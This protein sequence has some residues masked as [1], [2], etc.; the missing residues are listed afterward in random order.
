MGRLFQYN[1]EIVARHLDFIDDK[2]LKVVIEDRLGELE[3]VFSVN[4][5]L[6][7][8]ILSISC[9]EG[10]FK[11]L[12]SI[13]ASLIMG[14]RK[15]PMK[16]GGKKKKF[17][18]LTIEEIYNLLLEND[19]LQEIENFDQIYALFRSYRN[20]IH[21]QKQKKESWPVGLGQAQMA[22]GLLNATID[23]I[24]KYI[25]IGSEIFE[26]ISGSPRF[27]LSRILHL[28]VANIRTNSFIVLRRKID[29][30]FNVEFDLELGQ[31]GILNFVFDFV[32]EG[33]FK[34]LRLDNRGFRTPNCVLHCTQRYVWRQI[35]FA[36]P[37]LPPA[38]PTIP[39]KISADFAKR[40]FSLCV[41]GVGYKFKDI[42]G[43]DVDLFKEIK[44]NFRIGFFNEIGP[45]KLSNISFK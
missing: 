6:S 44:L 31:E 14:S 42:K 33:N 16:K 13:F 8:I 22:L 32:E 15:Y 36:T 34:M 40:V 30:A 9:I 12:A 19:V 7:T 10:I 39:V 18:E 11:H 41:D 37:E 38:K 4:G 27:D 23:Q 1:T 21:P 26:R 24:S 5:H 28:D 25:F 20:F 3:R 17:N 45:V 43:K 2:E 29:K 35:L